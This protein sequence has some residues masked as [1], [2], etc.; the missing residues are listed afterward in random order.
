MR[1]IIVIMLALTLPACAAGSAATTAS[2]TQ[3]SRP[4]VAAILAK[5]AAVPTPQVMQKSGLDAVIG[6]QANALIQQFGAARIDLIEGDA[7]KLQFSGDRCVLD[8]FLY[9]LSAGAAPVATHVEARLRSTGADTD[10]SSC[11]AELE[12]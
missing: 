10:R 9:P 7:R 1:N 8:I 2:S 12:D 5:P 4:T 6:A 11:I 3:A